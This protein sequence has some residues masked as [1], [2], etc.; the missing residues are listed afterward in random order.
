MI[1]ECLTTND[2]ILSGRGRREKGVSERNFLCLF[3]LVVYERS[4]NFKFKIIAFKGS[5]KETVNQERV[6]IKFQYSKLN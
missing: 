3:S 5:Q 1:E 2:V 6:A 4:A